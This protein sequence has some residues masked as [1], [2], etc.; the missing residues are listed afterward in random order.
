MWMKVRHLDCGGNLRQGLKFDEPI[1]LI[2]NSVLGSHWTG[3]C[4]VTIGPTD[5]NLEVE[6]EVEVKLGG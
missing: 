1:E 4:S 2:R 6:V 3:N 5:F